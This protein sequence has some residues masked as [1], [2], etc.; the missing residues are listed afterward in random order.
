MEATLQFWHKLC[1]KLRGTMRQ[2]ELARRNC[3]AN[4]FMTTASFDFNLTR[5]LILSFLLYAKAKTQ[6]ISVFS[7]ISVFQ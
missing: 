3:P 6:P 1:Q 2:L 5:L 7:S 4:S